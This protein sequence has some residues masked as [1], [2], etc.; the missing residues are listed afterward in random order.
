MRYYMSLAFRLALSW[1]A[2]GIELSCSS[3]RS[4]ANRLA[5][6]TLPLPRRLLVS[7]SPRL[8]VSSYVQ[9][10]ATSRQETGSIFISC[11]RKHK[12]AGSAKRAAAR[13]LPLTTEK[14][15]RIRIGWNLS[16]CF[17]GI[18]PLSRGPAKHVT[19][20]PHPCNLECQKPQCI[21][22]RHPFT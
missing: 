4:P 22:G 20:P 11:L 14:S 13:L 12:S 7:S 15:P 9:T 6:G 3:T 2:T 10:L 17:L 1:N 19:A 8:L 16:F 18:N 21:Y 5:S